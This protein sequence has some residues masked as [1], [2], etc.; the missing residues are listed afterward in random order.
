MK[1][2][3]VK[4]QPLVWIGMVHLILTNINLWI[5][6]LAIEIVEEYHHQIKHSNFVS[7]GLCWTLEHL[8]KL[9]FL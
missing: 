9:I 4:H 3:V 8:L 2:K 1:I 7:D 6:A 5:H